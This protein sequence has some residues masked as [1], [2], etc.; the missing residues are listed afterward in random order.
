MKTPFGEL[1]GAAK[2]LA[3]CAAIIFV[4]MGLCGLGWAMAGAM[5][6]KGQSLMSGLVIFGIIDGIVVIVAAVV[7][8]IAVI[9][10]LIRAAL[11]R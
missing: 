6:G 3:I 1:E 5:N 8:F 4:G 7:A 9:V 2:V 10:M 11:G